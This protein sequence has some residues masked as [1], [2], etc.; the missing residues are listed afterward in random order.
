MSS[1]KQCRVCDAL[2]VGKSVQPPVI[3]GAALNSSFSLP[4]IQKGPKIFLQIS[5]LETSKLLKVYWMS[6]AILIFDPNFKSVYSSVG[7]WTLAILSCN[8]CTKIAQGTLHIW[9]TSI[10]IRSLS[11]QTCIHTHLDV[12]DSLWQFASK[13][14]SRYGSIHR[15]RKILE[16]L[17]RLIK[18]TRMEAVCVCVYASMRSPSFNREWKN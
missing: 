6:L 15:W 2:S 11:F 7:E 1:I 10:S 9:L 14:A 3:I 18:V 8:Y 5:Y 17:N 12:L 16:A 13:K 4:W